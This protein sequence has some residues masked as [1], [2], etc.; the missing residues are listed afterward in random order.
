[1][2][3]F[4]RLV[5]CQT[6]NCRLPA[7]LRLS[8]GELL[9]RV[10]AVV[11]LRRDDID[12]GDG[13]DRVLGAALAGATDSALCWRVSFGAAS[14]V[15]SFSFSFLAV[16]PAAWALE[17]LLVGPGAQHDELVGPVDAL[18]DTSRLTR[19]LACGVAIGVQRAGAHLGQHRA[20]LDVGDRVERGV[21][22]WGGA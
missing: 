22:S 15:P 4:G 5:C 12:M 8:V 19:V 13:E 11:L 1:M 6:S 18:I 3:W 14:M 7:C 10:D 2:K 17:R 16:S 9:Q 20:D 21:L